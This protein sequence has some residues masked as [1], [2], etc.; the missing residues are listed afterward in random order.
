MDNGSITAAQVT[1]RSNRPC[2][3]KRWRTTLGM[4]NAVAMGGSS[5]KTAEL[6]KS[7]ACY[8]C[9]RAKIVR[10]VKPC[11]NVHRESG[12]LAAILESRLWPPCSPKPRL[13]GGTKSSLYGA[14]RHLLA[15]L[16][17][18]ATTCW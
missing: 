4:G 10:I 14:L 18:L 16:L 5:R 17:L 3:R 11:R 13:I 1:T 7:S 2:S 6:H 15:L 9:P 12:A 8:S